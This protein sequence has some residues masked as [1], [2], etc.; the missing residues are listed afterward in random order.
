MKFTVTVTGVLRRDHH[1]RKG[2]MQY[3]FVI[4]AVLYILVAAVGFTPS[5]QAHFAGYY[6]IYPIAHIHGA[7]MTIFLLLF[8]AQTLFVAQGNRALHRKFGTASFFVAAPAWVSMLL[9]TR[10]PLVAE[11]LPVDHF[12]YDVL[13]V[14]LMLI[15]LFPILFIWGLAARRKPQVHKRVMCFLLLLILQVSIDRMR[16]LP[17]FGLPKHFGS[18]IYVYLLALPLLAFD[19]ITLGRIHKTTVL[20]LSI[21][22]MAHFGVSVLFNSPSWHKFASSATNFIR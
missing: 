20:C 16:W 5:Y 17:S 13:L 22:V 6:H 19:L 8:L 1:K 2:F 21:L 12:L 4:L 10:R 14:Q 15:L 3:Y 11:V 7:L 18:D 9:A